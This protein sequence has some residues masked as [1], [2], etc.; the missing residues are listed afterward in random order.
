MR[1][2]LGTSA[3]AL[4]VVLC[5]G[6]PTALA[7]DPPKPAAASAATPA[8]LPPEW[9]ALQASLHPQAGDVT[10]PAAKAVLHLGDRYYYLPPDEAKRVLVDVWKNPPSA[11]NDT[12]GL[13]LEKGT[14]FY[15]NVWG[16][17]ITYQDSGHVSDADAKNQDYAKV[18]SDMQAGDAEDNQQR[19]SQGYPTMRLVGWAQAPSYDPANHSLIWA[20]EYDNEGQREHGLNYDIRLLGRT[21]VLSLNML[22]GVSS[23]PDV[24]AA[25]ETFGKSV[26]FQ[27][28]AAYSDFDVKIDKTAEY[29][30]AGL[31]AGGAAVAVASK[32]GLLAILLKFAKLIVIGVIAF[33]AGIW[34]FA[35]RL[36]GRKRDEDAI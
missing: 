7:K 21:G 27:P 20:R 32:L 16:A 18:L 30:L 1:K 3:V 13:V 36:L 9:A 15:D 24:R 6:A 19:K 2:L 10:I 35:R 25:A 12:L 26:T 34:A 31:V 14:T 22:S 11:V 8:K 4:A 17:V 28:G 33:G 29:G 23:L 5:A